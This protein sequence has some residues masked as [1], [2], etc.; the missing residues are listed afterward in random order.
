METFIF[1]DGASKGNPGPGGWGAVI[2]KEDSIEEIGNRE[3]QTT[4]NRME[5]TSVV[6]AL[7][8]ASQE[9]ERK[10]VVFTDSSYVINGITKWIYGWEKNGWKTKTKTDVLNIDLWKQL[11]GVSH[12]QEIEWRYVPGHSDIAGNER[13]NDIAETFAFNKTPE[14][15]S[16]AITDYSKKLLLKKMPLDRDGNVSLLKKNENTKKR[17]KGVAYS[18]VSLLDGKIETHK[19]WNECKMRV[20]GKPARFKKALSKKEEEEI[21]REYKQ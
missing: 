6:K 7:E 14:L 9:E 18:Y 16:G 5:L 17:K 3:P 21:I 12:N 2:Q 10:V 15:Y 19:T 20:E 4:N 13:A 1:T 8:R 11:S